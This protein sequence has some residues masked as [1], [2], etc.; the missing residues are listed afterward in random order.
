VSSLWTPGGEHRV[1]RSTDDEPQDQAARPPG[2]DADDEQTLDEAAL[3]AEID[4]ARARVAEVPAEVVVL[5]HAMGL[6]ELAAI[7]LSAAP[8]NLPA[9][10][11]AIDAFACLVEGLGDRIGPEASTLRDALAQIR[12]AFVQVKQS[13]GASAAEGPAG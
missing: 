7:H 11:L 5:N 2:A 12:M 8:P 6:Y 13:S 9:S 1:P 3:R 4:E 10:A